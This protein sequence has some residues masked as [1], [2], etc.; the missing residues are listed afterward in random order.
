MIKLPFLRFLL[1]GNCHQFGSNNLIK[2]LIGLYASYFDKEKITQGHRVDIITEVNNGFKIE[3][4]LQF[5]SVLGTKIKH[6]YWE[7]FEDH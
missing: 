6:N 3:T 5:I 4:T 1:P 7:S 2:I